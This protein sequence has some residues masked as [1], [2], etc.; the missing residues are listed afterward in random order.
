MWYPCKK[1]FFE[2][3]KIICLFVK[4]F[5]KIG[6]NYYVKDYSLLL[7]GVRQEKGTEEF[8]FDF[9]LIPY[10]WCFWTITLSFIGISRASKG[11]ASRQ[12]NTMVLKYILL[13]A[14]VTTKF[15]KIRLYES[16]IPRPLVFAFLYMCPLLMVGSVN[17]DMFAKNIRRNK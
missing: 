3:V 1:L 5:I 2:F 14:A 4:I 15:P 8:W 17:M 13:S 9:H 6:Y 12:P 10:M 11:E 7:S 16:Q